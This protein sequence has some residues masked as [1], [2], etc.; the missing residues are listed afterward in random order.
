MQG[1]AEVSGASRGEQRQRW[2]ALRCHPTDERIG[3]LLHQRLVARTVRTGSF[4][5]EPLAL[6]LLVLAVVALEE[7]PLRVVLRREDVRRDAIEEPAIVRDDEHAAGELEQR[8]LERPQCLDR[9]E[10]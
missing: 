10:E 3:E 7:Y 9:S 2:Q 1:S 6:V 5:A 4:L 8:L